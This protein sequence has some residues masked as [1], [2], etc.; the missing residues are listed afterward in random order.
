MKNNPLSKILKTLSKNLLDQYS[1]EEIKQE[2][3]IKLWMN[4]DIE[5]YQG[6]LAYN[7]FVYKKYDEHKRT[8]GHKTVRLK[9]NIP[10]KA[11]IFITDSYIKEF[12]DSF[13]K[14]DRGQISLVLQPFLKHLYLGKDYGSYEEL[15]EELSISKSNLYRI[16]H[17]IRKKLTN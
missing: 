8:H 12:I 1:E 10:A 11:G 17:S 9:K 3:E 5:G 14:I 15:A 7:E 2:E 16:L 6:L 13:E 4:P